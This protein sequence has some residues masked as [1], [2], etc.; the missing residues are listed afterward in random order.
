MSISNPSPNLTNLALVH[1]RKAA[2]ITNIETVRYFTDKDLQELKTRIHLSLEC[3]EVV[4]SNQSKL[5][6]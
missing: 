3:L 6:V 1:L 4:G 2:E 5:Q